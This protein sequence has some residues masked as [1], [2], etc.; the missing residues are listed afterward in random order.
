MSAPYVGEIRAFGFGF[1]PVGWLA[2]DGSTVSI[3]QYQSLFNLIGTTYG[4]DGVQ[5]FKLP[6]FNGQAPLGAGQG[7]GLS[8]YQLGGTVGSTTVTLTAN[9][10]PQHNH[11]IVGIV[12]SSADTYAK[13][14][15]TSRLSRVFAA[16]TILNSYSD[17]PVTGK[18]AP[19]TLAM[20]GGG[21]PHEN[22]QPYLVVNFAIATDG[23]YPTAG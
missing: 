10:M 5:S 17:Q 2:C 19:E 16:G 4:G 12:A 15:A 14:N 6:N 20:T 11:S 8:A 9:Q 7:P 3:S 21:S 22:M 1:I 13:P 18:L 23:I